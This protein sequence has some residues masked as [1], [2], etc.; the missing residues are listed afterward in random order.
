MT[1]EQQQYLSGYIQGVTDAGK[2]E[3]GVE[4]TESNREN[5]EIQALLEPELNT[6]LEEDLNS[7]VRKVEDLI[8]VNDWSFEVY[9]E[10]KL[11]VKQEER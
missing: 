3:F 2:F 6:K 4:S 5:T 11:I 9:Y 7:L 8:R 1:Q 10:I